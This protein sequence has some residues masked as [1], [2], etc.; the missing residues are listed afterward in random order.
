MPLVLGAL[1]GGAVVEALERGGAVLDMGCGA[2][3]AV[4]CIAA[5]FPRSH[6]DG[7]DPDGAA[8]Q[9]GRRDA[10]ADGLANASFHRAFGEEYEAGVAYD[11]CVCLD[12][13]HGAAVPL[14]HLHPVCAAQRVV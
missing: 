6:V 13:I 7:V 9:V 2:G 4:N 5:A 10:A 14:F 11:L 12:I 1:D 3:V 8:L